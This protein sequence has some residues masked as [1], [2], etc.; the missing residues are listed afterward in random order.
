MPDPI[1]PTTGEQLLSRLPDTPDVYL[2]N[3][4]PVNSK[5][6]LIEFDFAA[7]RRSSFL[8]N[9]ILS[10]STKGAWLPLHNVI[11]AAG[12]SKNLR[13]LHYIFH[14]G[15]VGSTLI[16]RLLDEIA[17]VWS[18]REPLP[19]RSLADLHDQPDQPQSIPDHRQF[20]T[21][22]RALVQIWSRGYE[23][24]HSIVVKATSSAARV[25]AP[26]LSLEPASRALYLNIAAETYLA[27]LL[28][29]ESSHGDLHKLGPGRMQRLQKRLDVQLAPL[30]SMSV[31]EVAAMSWLVESLTQRDVVQACGTR[32]LC[33]DFDEFLGNVT[34]GMSRIIRHFNLP[35]GQE[36]LSQVAHSPVFTRYSKATE[37]GYSPQFR[38]QV[39]AQSRHRHSVEIARGTQWLECMA[40]AHRSLNLHQ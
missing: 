12:L 37:Y 4:D 16:S 30:D 24:T 34:A 27:T 32:I 33:V 31:G 14:T 26:L 23:A 5:G 25:A 3:V 28:A 39:L 36:Y 13:P 40:R 19:L 35:A 6:L 8:D 11:A 20:M 17:G 2:Q 29:G 15:H 10:P 38:A 9:R 18:L 21:L 7:Y 1:Y 22:A